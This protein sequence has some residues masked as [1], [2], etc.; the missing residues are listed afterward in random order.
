MLFCIIFRCYWKSAAVDFK[1]CLYTFSETIE[2]CQGNVNGVCS[3]RIEEV[4]MMLDLLVVGAD[5]KMVELAC[6]KANSRHGCRG[7]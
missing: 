3:C 2:E 6:F 1:L 4:E 7:Q 5:I